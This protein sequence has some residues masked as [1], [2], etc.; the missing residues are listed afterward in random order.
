MISIE[1]LLHLLDICHMKQD[2]LQLKLDIW[3]MKPDIRHMKQDNLQMKLDLRQMKPDIRHMKQDI[4]QMKLDIRQIQPNTSVC[5]SETQ[6]LQRHIILTHCA[7][8]RESFIVI[9]I[10]R[11]H[12]EEQCP[13]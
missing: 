11:I 6:I 2:I 5:N 9:L 12:P 7:Y 3:Q 1:K 10:S 13:L 8:I 4:L